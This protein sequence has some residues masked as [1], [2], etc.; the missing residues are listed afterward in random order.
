M[1]Q[2]MITLI[3]TESFFVHSSHLL[4]ISMILM[5]FFRGM[6][7]HTQE[8]TSSHQTVKNI[9]PIPQLPIQG[10]Q[11]Y[12]AARC[13]SWRPTYSVIDITDTTLTVTTYDAATNEKLV[14]DGGIDTTYTIVKQADKTALESEITKAENSLKEAKDSGNKTEESVKALSDTIT[15]AKAVLDKAE[16]TNEDIA[17]AVAALQ[18]AIKGLKEISKTD[19]SD[20]TEVTPEKEIAGSN[21]GDATRPMAV[22]FAIAGASMAGLA[23]IAVSEKK[24][25][26]E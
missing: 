19:S 1:V 21:T 3:L 5:L 10:T 16:S 26:A 7:T 2:D 15:R 20:K 12:I 18:E 13:Q 6:T 11:N 25:K 24:R 4:L 9:I 17:S 23:A 8:H 14:A 22:W